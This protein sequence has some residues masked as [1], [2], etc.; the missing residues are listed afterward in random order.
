MTTETAIATTEPQPKV[1]N[2]PEHYR[3]GECGVT[4]VR[5]WREYNTFLDYQ[6]L[7]CRVCATKAQNKTAEAIEESIRHGRCDQI[8][9]LVPAVPTRDGST[10]WGYSS[11]PQGLCNW[12]NSLPNALDE[13][14]P[15]DQQSL[16]DVLDEFRFS[17][18]AKASGRTGAHL[19]FEES[20][21]AIFLIVQAPDAAA[22]KAA[23]LHAIVERE[24]TPA[25]EKQAARYALARLGKDTTVVISSADHTIT[26]ST[27]RD[28]G[29][30]LASMADDHNEAIT[31]KALR[32][33]LGLKARTNPSA[34]AGIRAFTNADLGYRFERR[35]VTICEG[36]G[37]IYTMTFGDLQRNACKRA[38][39]RLDE[40]LGIT[41]A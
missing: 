23:K 21:Q 39:E 25:S 32:Y 17:R 35:G 31:T 28:L 40:E 18:G 36:G 10:F 22:A 7:Y 33:F 16:L 38:L 2:S 11:V 27:L 34:Y 9:W 37:P 20:D 41:P 13:T 19:T 26:V 8:G 30:V 1:Y 4:G 5:L 14:L 12:W 24:T 3:C 6:H 15:V 29:A